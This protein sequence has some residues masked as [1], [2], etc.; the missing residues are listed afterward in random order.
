MIIEIKIPS[1]GESITEVEVASWLVDND[2]IV[3]KDQ[4]VAE[5]ESEKAL[6]GMHNIV[7]RPVAVEGRMEIRPVTYLALS[8]DHRLV[9]GRDSVGFLKSIKEMIE[10]PASMLFGGKDAE[11]LLLEL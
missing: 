6:L 11:R 3:E 2:N 4:E 10:A 9:D 1:P 7:G 8:H 5:I